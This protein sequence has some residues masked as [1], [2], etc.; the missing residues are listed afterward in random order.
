MET[1]LMEEGMEIDYTSFY[2]PKATVPGNYSNEGFQKKE[3]DP[4]RTG[5]VIDMMN[6]YNLGTTFFKL[7][8]DKVLT[9]IDPSKPGV[10]RLYRKVVQ[11]YAGRIQDPDNPKIFMNVQIPRVEEFL[12][13]AG[14]TEE[15]KSKINFLRN[16][17]K[18]FSEFTS[19]KNRGKFTQIQN[20][21]PSLSRI[22]QS[23]YVYGKLIKVINSSKGEIKKEELGHVR[24]FKF[25]KG[26]VGKTDFITVFNNS[27]QNKIQALGSS[28]WMKDY[29]S[30]AEGEFTKVISVN[31]GQSTGKLKKYSLGVTLEEMAPFKVT[32]ED[33]E[34]A[35]NLNSRVFD[36]TKYDE[37]YYER[38]SR[39][40]NNVQSVIDRLA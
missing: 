37:K 7:I 21:L 11:G 27:L 5:Q 25:S 4:T 29:F 17:A 26:E 9:V 32:A 30:R 16:Q 22:P 31:V 40:F 18:N 12:P 8:P 38:L 10:P 24:V 19:F 20:M 2:T 13:E 34:V 28:S 36:I 35:G 39:A 3:S 6:S 14:L 15:Q 23:V 33:L 1:F